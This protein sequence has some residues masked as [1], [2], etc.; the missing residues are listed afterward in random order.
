M[1]MTPAYALVASLADKITLPV[2]YQDIRKLLSKPEATIDDF[3]DV[4]RLDSALSL[5][6]IKVANSHFFGY[7]RKSE[8]V[9]QAITMLGMLQI[10]DL[11]LSS[12][13]I[14]AFSTISTDIFNQHAFWR[15]CIYCGILARMLAQKCMLPAK[16]R[17]FTAGLL[18]EIGHIVMFSKMSEKMQDILIES[19]QSDK[20]VSLLERESLGFDY[21]DVGGEVMLL[22]HL[23]ESYYSIAKFHMTPKKA[24]EKGYELEAQIVNLA[25]SIMLDEELGIE[26]SVALYLNANDLIKRKVTMQELNGMKIDAKLNVDEIMDCLWPFVKET[27][28]SSDITE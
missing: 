6:I 9:K 5:R 22:W 13:A 2:V 25:R 3:V 8:T 11:L 15:S 19:L 16:E 27:P 21:G 1:I 17:L 26:H 14:R 10:H 24:K 12:L 4:I 23:P 7:S 18:H 20:P 28:F